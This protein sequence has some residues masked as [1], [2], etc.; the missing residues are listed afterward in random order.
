MACKADEIVRTQGVLR[1]ASAFLAR[2][3]VFVPRGEREQ[4]GR[5]RQPG[6]VSSLLQSNELATAVRS[7][8]SPHCCDRPP[9]VGSP[10][11]RRVAGRERLQ[12]PFLDDIER[13]GEWRRRLRLDRKGNDI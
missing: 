2:I 5:K 11:R 9:R 3:L 7:R 4:A 1:P 13:L 12:S 8:S 10:V 6:A